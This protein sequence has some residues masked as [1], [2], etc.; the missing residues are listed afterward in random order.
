MGKAPSLAARLAAVA[1]QPNTTSYEPP[2]PANLAPAPTT[3]ATLPPEVKNEP[4]PMGSTPVAP[5]NFSQPVYSPMPQAKP[6]A[7]EGRVMVAGYFSPELSR[8]LRILAAE[9]DVTIQY[10]IGEGLDFVLRHY[11]KHPMGER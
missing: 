9:R 2:A 4:I 7:R 5:P 8:A 3:G 10:L 11:G 1:T 6:K